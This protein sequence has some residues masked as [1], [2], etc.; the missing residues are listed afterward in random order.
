MVQAGFDENPVVRKLAILV[1]SVTYRSVDD[2]VSKL[3][4]QISSEH[5]AENMSSS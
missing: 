4:P 1:F 5:A 2:A 3:L